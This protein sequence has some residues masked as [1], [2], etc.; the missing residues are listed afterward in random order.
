MSST[1]LLIAFFEVSVASR[2]HQL[3]ITYANMINPELGVSVGSRY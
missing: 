2:Y 1:K 3:V